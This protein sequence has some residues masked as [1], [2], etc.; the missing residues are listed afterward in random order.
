MRAVVQRVQCARVRVGGETVAEMGAGLLAF[1]GVVRG[2]G[3]GDAQ[4]LGRKLAHLRILADE[5]GRMNRS[6]AAAG[7]T[8]CVVSQFTLLG[9]AR[10]GHRP[11][12]AAAAPPEEAEPL[13][14]GVVRAAEAEGVAVVTG[15]FRAHMRVELANDG[16][17]TVLLDTGRLF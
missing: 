1:V 16:P 15:R 14:E 11:S 10:R 17:V 3:P 9:D 12:F 6:L 4:R 2:D 8:L 5:E 7:G 13:V